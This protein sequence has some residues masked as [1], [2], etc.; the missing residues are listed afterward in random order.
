MTKIEAILN[1][2]RCLSPAERAQLVEQLLEVSSGTQA[3]EVAA[4][5]RGLA[6]WTEAVHGEDWSAFYPE[7]LRNGQRGT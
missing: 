4:G 2:A 7:S 3:D 6:M 1:D 5:Q